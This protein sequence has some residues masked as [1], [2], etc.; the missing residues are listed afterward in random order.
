MASLDLLRS[1]VLPWEPESTET[2]YGCTGCGRC[3]N[4]CNHSNEVAEALMAG[5][6]AAAARD[7]ASPA[8]TGFAARFSLRQRTLR[9]ALRATAAAAE[10][11][12]DAPVAFAPACD[13]VAQDAPGALRSAQVAFAQAGTSYVRLLPAPPRSTEGE[14]VCLGYP[15]YAA[16]ELD[17]LAELASTVV[18]AAADC[19]QLIVQCAGCAWLWRTKRRQ[20][21][22]PSS[23]ELVH[24]SELLTSGAARLPARATLGDV[25]WH[26]PCHLGRG[27]GVYAPPRQALSRVANVIEL[28]D[29]G[30][31]AGCCGGGGLLPLTAPSTA[32]AIASERLAAVPAGATV[33]TGCS[34]CQRSFRRVRPDLRVLELLEAI[35]VALAPRD[36]PSAGSHSEVN[37]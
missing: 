32:R 36:L 24:C 25:Y 34:T 7:A 2:L 16:G 13:A 33:V 23:V 21:G 18:A 14:P 9:Q 22:L 8:L 35:E 29:H 12:G 30:P 19:R 1:G 15:L 6:A 31:E 17:A 28:R 4:F 37:R 5:R 10:L 27:L 11:R 3:K 20:L 26:D